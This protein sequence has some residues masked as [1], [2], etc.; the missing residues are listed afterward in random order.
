MRNP[1]PARLGALPLALALVLA[2][3]LSGCDDGNSSTRATTVFGETAGTSGGGAVQGNFR[4]LSTSVVEGSVVEVNRPIALTFDRPVDFATVG[5]NTIRVHSLAGLAATGTFGPRRFDA[6]GD[7]HAESVDETTVVF[8]PACPRQADGSDA[9]LRLGGTPYTVVVEGAE[10]GA[11][12]VLRAG[13]GSV[14]ARSA[15]VSFTTP[16]ASGLQGGTLDPVAGPPRPVLRAR[17]A[18]GESATR[19]VVGGDREVHLELD[20]S[21]Q[22]VAPS[23][24]GFLLPRNLEAEAATRVALHLVFDQ[25]IDPATSNLARIGWEFE[26]VSGWIPLETRRDLVANCTGLT[27]VIASP[28]GVLPSGRRVRVVLGAGFR[29]L[30]GEELLIAETDF[31]LVTTETTRFGSLAPEELL[32]DR[33]LGAFG[34]PATGATNLAASGTSLDATSEVPCGGGP[35]GNFDWV[36][37]SG[38]IFLFDTSG[39]SVPGGPNGTPT[40]IQTSANGFVEVRD[41]IVEPGGE[42]RVQGPNPFRVCASRDVVVRGVLRLNGF[43]GKDVATLNTGHIPEVGAAGGPAGGAGGNASEV[44]DGSTPRGGTGKGPT[45]LLEG[46]QGGESA[47]A[48]PDLGK[49]ARRPGGGGGGRFAADQGAYVATDGSPGHPSSTGAESGLSPA[50]GG[51]PGAGPF[52]DGDPDND[53]FGKQVVREGSDGVLELVQGE[54]T[55]LQGGYGGGGGGDAVPSDVFP[56]PQWN[57]ASDEKGGPGGG[58]GGVARIRAFGRIVIGRAG[59]IA[60]RGGQGGVGENTLFLDHVGGTG[61]SGSGGMVV[62]ETPTQIDF[63]DGDPAGRNLRPFVDARGIE[64]KIGPVSGGVPLGVS[65]GG[66][67]GPGLIELV[68]PLDAQTPTDDLAGGLV[69]PTAALSK[70]QPLAGVTRPTAV[71]LLSDFDYRPVAT[72][73]WISLG[74]AG[75]GP[76][77]AAGP[78]SFLFGG[79]EESGRVRTTPEGRVAGVAPLVGPL[80]LTA[81][82]VELSQDGTSIALS[83][84]ALAGLHADD[85]LYLRTPALLESF[86]LRLAT[87]AATVDHAIASASYEEESGTLRLILALDGASRRRAATG[88]PHETTLALVPRFFR[89]ATDG[90]AGHLPP[91]AEVRVRFQA[92]GGSAGVPDPEDVLVDWTADAGALGSALSATGVRPAWLRFQVG[93][94]LDPAR[95]GPGGPAGVSFELLG[96]P[97]A[98]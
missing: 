59:K 77:G 80:A 10:T 72:S 33:L 73:R 28:G 44:T 23:V 36:V 56:Q 15:S 52:V 88:S 26:S 2:G 87:P 58:G 64:G 12:N 85:A 79:L 25:P 61:G 30:A 90:V 19:F 78:L 14:L 86:A 16:N 43:D 18:S 63:T 21:A 9:G 62:L 98:F 22:T 46:A 8:R 82:G 83:G 75:V 35:G 42:L 81:A 71:T 3:T 45:G 31:A 5:P 91:S 70:A 74:A 40:A 60:S 51:V 66:D 24:T 95:R 37:R 49:D 84:A 94:D 97:F 68:L 13:D 48:P 41:L 7:G 4:L 1:R 47:Y 55:G 6:D 57:P 54:L 27:E 53:F 89:V 34:P 69:V 50:A 17:G 93:F 67:G 32:A 96:M 65:H 11:A 39:T 20:A 38:E 76:A 92:V 29:D